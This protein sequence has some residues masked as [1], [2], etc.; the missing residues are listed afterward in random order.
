MTPSGIDILEKTLALLGVPAGIPHGL[1][2]R[3][4]RVLCALPRERETALRTLSVYQPQRL[5]AR[6]LASGFRVACSANAHM[7]FLKRWRMPPHDS[8]SPFDGHQLAPG[9]MIGSPGHLCERAVAC[10]RV[11]GE[12]QIWKIAFGETGRE[13]LETEASMLAFLASRKH[14]ESPRSLGLA[15]HRDATILKMAWLGGNPWK[16]EA[17][18]P[19]LGILDAWLRDDLDPTPLENFAE[20]KWIMPT[21]ARH[22]PWSDRL[23]QLGALPLRP[24]IRHGDL[25]RPNLR[26]GVTVPVVVHDWERGVPDGLPCVDLV[27]YLTQ[28]L[29]F[30]KRL[31]PREVT[32]AVAARLSEA[33]VSNCLL[34]TG[35]GHRINELMVCAYAINTGAGY[36]DQTALI[37][38]ATS[39]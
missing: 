26:Q 15:H 12:W 23:D 22:K 3:D 19:L 32:R 7:M 34:A 10:L 30:R 38:S 8:S 20:W 37:E 1:L 2:M 9:V 21:L 27:H 17:I 25:T 11:G 33:D 13:I 31:P 35:W 24:S 18:A 29:V 6:C 28:D 5:A 14:Q 4:G 16:S 39:T 36:I